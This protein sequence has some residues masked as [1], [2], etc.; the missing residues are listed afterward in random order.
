MIQNQFFKQIIGAISLSMLLSSILIL[1]LAA[2]TDQPG[3]NP[4]TTPQQSGQVPDDSQRSLKIPNPADVQSNYP[5]QMSRKKHYLMPS[6]STN[7]PYIPPAEA[8]GTTSP[9][10]D[11]NGS[12]TGNLGGGMSRPVS[13]GPAYRSTSPSPTPAPVGVGPQVSYQNGTRTIKVNEGTR[14]ITIV[15]HP[16]TGIDIEIIRHYGPDQMQ[17]LKRRLPE[18]SDYVELFPTEI[19][20]AEISLNIGVKSKYT[21]L[22]PDQLKSEH[23]DA[24]EIYSR[25]VQYRRSNT[26]SARITTRKSHGARA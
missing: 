24:Y 8:S 17:A 25:Y 7:G 19:D 18:L 16:T 11:R 13:G 6:H 15:D 5:W 23:P 1:P 2:Q 3:S 10:N 20:K 26:I 9:A 4:S 22:T 21:A 14:E 12:T